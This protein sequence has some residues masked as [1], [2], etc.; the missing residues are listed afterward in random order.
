MKTH[1]YFVPNVNFFGPNAVNVTA[2]RAQLLNMKKPLIVTDTFLKDLE[3]GPVKQVISLLND[4]NIG[5][6]IYD[7]VEPNPKIANCLD[8]M[9]VYNE[10]KCD[11][12]ITIG[13]G[14]SH[15]CGKG[16]GI[17]AT[18][19]GDLTDYAGIETL[20]NELPPIIAVN[21]T[22]GTGSEV[23]RHCVLTNSE[24]KLKFVIVSW[25]NVP[26]VSINDPLLMLSVP[27]GLT[28]ATGI[29]ALTH[30]VESYVSVN[31]NPVTDASSIQAMKLIATNLRQAVANGEN[32][33]ARENMAYAS[34]LAGMA[35]NNADLGYVHAM[36]HQLG[37][38]YDMAHGVAN[39]ILLPTVEEYNIISNP[40]R[41]ADIAEFM[42]ENIEGLSTM[43][44]AQLAIHALRDISEDVGIPGTLEEMGVKEEDFELM[45]ENALKDGN[46]FSNPRKGTKEDI[47]ELF[48]K[49]Y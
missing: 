30:A 49:A 28:A 16:I 13:G 12:I 8:G 43:E 41:F 35:F 25:R 26:L 18:H 29:D 24:T 31:A 19:D 37:G 48:K 46:A 23:T 45:A 17:A 36:A 39:A 5:H 32:L 7:G 11:G 21:T 44:A 27:K 15:D 10:N 42:G 40:Q 20:T 22:A 38:Q 33:E 4:E 3:D 1:D 6:A 47:I 2:E 34:L 14:S 9:K